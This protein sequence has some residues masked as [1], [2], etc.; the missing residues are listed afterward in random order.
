MLEAIDGQMDLEID[1]LVECTPDVALVF[2][3]VDTVHDQNK[4]ALDTFYGYRQ[5]SVVP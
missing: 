5:T 3:I 1:D 2:L 4:L